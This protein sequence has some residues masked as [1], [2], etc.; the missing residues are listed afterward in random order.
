MRRSKTF[1][2]RPFAQ[3]VMPRWHH[4]SHRNSSFSVFITYHLSLESV[5]PELLHRPC[6][7]V[8]NRFW[9]I[10][11]ELNDMC[12]YGLDDDYD[13]NDDIDELYDCTHQGCWVDTCYHC[14]CY[15]STIVSIIL[16]VICMISSATHHGC[17]LTTWPPCLQVLIFHQWQLIFFFGA[18]N[19]W[20]YLQRL[21]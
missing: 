3:L 14:Y 4:R 17:S 18:E 2:I 16:I 20:W 10:F 6:S 8:A 9:N 12:D 21:I 13:N 19:V 7:T 11:C 5:C 15:L 1:K